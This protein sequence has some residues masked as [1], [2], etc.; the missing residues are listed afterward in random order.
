MRV[1]RITRHALDRHRQYRPDAAANIYDR[2]QRIADD[3]R[4][5]L[6]AGRV[7]ARE[8]RFTRDVEL[9]GRK[10]RGSDRSIRFVWTEDERLVYVIDKL[11][12]ETVVVT[13]LPGRDDS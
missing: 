7:K 4:F 12:R 5:A 9:Y 2:Q 1:V 10:K 3:V 8:P 11:A 13:C 6:L